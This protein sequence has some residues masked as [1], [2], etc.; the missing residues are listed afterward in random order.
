MVWDEK[1]T[2]RKKGSRT[3]ATVV[4]EDTSGKIVG[5]TNMNVNG[6]EW[7]KPRYEDD[8]IIFPDKEKEKQRRDRA[9]KKNRKKKHK[10]K[11]ARRKNR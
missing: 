9:R 6:T 2:C 3:E 8:K 11:Q 7:E 5:D 4:A 1:D 10:Q